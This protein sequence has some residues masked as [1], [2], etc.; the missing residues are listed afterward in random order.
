MAAIVYIQRRVCSATGTHG[1]GSP[2]PN[3]S[4]S[5]ESLCKGEWRAHKRMLQV[6]GAQV[7]RRTGRQGHNDSEA[8]QRSTTTFQKTLKDRKA[9]PVDMQG[10]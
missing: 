5:R 2:K 9:P 10:R 7:N 8:S 6:R 1:S 3:G 4:A